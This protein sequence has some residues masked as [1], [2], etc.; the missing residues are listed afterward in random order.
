M[1]RIRRGSSASED[2]EMYTRGI[3]AFIL[4]KLVKSDH[5]GGSFLP[6][7]SLNTV[8]E[9]IDFDRL[10]PDASTALIEF[11]K[12]EAMKVF[13]ATLISVEIDGYKLKKIAESFK[14]NRLTDKSLPVN[15]IAEH[16][17]CAYRCDCD[18]CIHTRRERRCKHD[19]AMDSFHRVWG[20]VSFRNFLQNQWKFC[21]PVFKRNTI[22]QFENELPEETILPFVGKDD[23]QHSGH[24][25]DVF[26]VKLHAAHQEEHNPNGGDV[27]IALKALKN[28]PDEGIDYDVENAF[29]LEVNTLSELAGLNHQHLIRPI[30]AFKW[31]ATNYIMFEWAN[32]GTLRTFWAKNRNAHLGLTSGRIKEFL[33]QLRG[34]S[35]ALCKL[36]N[37]RIQTNTT[38]TQAGSLSLKVPQNGRRMLSVGKAMPSPANNLPTIV[39]P[40]EDGDNDAKHWRHGDLKPENILI[41]TNSSWLGNLKIADL[42]L[43]KQHE[44]ATALRVEATSTKHTTLHYEAPEAVTNKLEPRSR[45]YDIWSMGCIV[46]ESILWLLYGYQGLDAFYGEKNNFQSQAGQTLYFTTKQ[47][48]SSFVSDTVTHWISEILERDPECNETTALHDLLVLLRDRLLVAEVS[49]RATASEL[50][51]ALKSIEDTARSNSK[52]LFTGTRRKDVQTPWSFNSRKRSA[53]QPKTHGHLGPMT[54][55][56]TQQAMFDDTW[57]FLP[58]N[59]I[60][61]HLMEPGKCN[62]LHSLPKI[63]ASLCRRC[64]TLNFKVLGFVVRENFFSL[65]LRAESCNLCRLF[66]HVFDTSDMFNKSKASDM[67]FWRVR[68]GLAL[69]KNGAPILSICETNPTDS[70]LDTPVPD[71]PIGLPNLAAVAS[72]AYF[73]ILH[74]W[75]EDCDKHHKD[76]QPEKTESLGRIPTRLIDVEDKNSST[77]RLLE[78]KESQIYLTEPIKYIAVSHPWGDKNEHNHYC[79]TQLNLDQHRA[80]IRV[81]VLP[82]TFQDAIRITRQLGVQYLWIDSLC[83]IQ[84]TDGDFNK[85]AEHMETV[86]S[87]AYCVIA[88]TC[89]DGMSSGFLKSRPDRKVVKIE[90]LRE[91][92]FY[93]CE[94]IDNFQRDVI[95]GPL[96]KRG[97][98]LQERAL[99]RR[100][101][102]FAENQTY[103][104]CGEGVRCETLTRMKNNQAAFLG[105][106]KFPRVA[107]ESSKGSR[108]SLYQ[109]LYKQYSRLEFTKIH[110]RPLAIAGIEQRLIRAFET[111]GGYG[112][113]NRYFGRSLLWQR[114]KTLPLQVMKP[115][116]FP[117]SQPYQIP[118]WSWMAYEGA[119]DFMYLPF[120]EVDWEKKEICSPWNPPTT[121]LASSSRLNITSNASWHTADT[122]GRNDLTAIARDFSVAA[123]PYVIYDRNERPKDHIV[124]CVVVGRSKVKTG[125]NRTHYVLVVA[126]QTDASLNAGYKRIGVAKLPGNLIGLE[127]DGIQ[128]Q[129]F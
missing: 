99:A 35:D 33:A 91:S 66:L 86:F 106:P 18:K 113:F 1:T 114:D 29:R 26:H 46:F 82:N 27:N 6:E 19:Q 32:G 55:G 9:Y 65:N 57:E 11:I 41:F 74:G 93:I 63:T 100:T 98:V 121:L 128:V 83:I 37:T 124:K 50:H 79:T 84:G 56:Q 87:S 88:A 81:D 36:H 60:Y 31:R 10:L 51:S 44:F 75:L 38:L 70:S 59:I 20:P 120:G 104:E 76:C 118:S 97:W 64:L 8:A 30:S 24:F 42:G 126:Q 116:Q 2:D 102:Y 72:E 39:G 119:I 90:R 14:A 7:S 53:L 107:T 17:M 5:Y 73:N 45:R 23:R 89:A 92:P 21:A 103:W 22:Q 28:T 48:Q 77:V 96:N 3:Y 108:I 54:H 12:K 58:D 85:E 4:G 129:V 123:D 25:S 78:T 125:V 101:I 16:G 112:V 95:E 68:G 71:I 67:E 111:Q 47:D 43:A 69:T 94:S 117:Q 105:D 61:A 115:I 15:D 40:P 110:D 127:G 122:N 49:S 52:Y 80:K 62:F 13:L 34:I 109:L